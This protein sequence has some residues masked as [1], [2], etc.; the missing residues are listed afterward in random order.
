[1]KTD[2]PEV[3]WEGMD[4]TN[5]AQDGVM[6]VCECGNEPSGSINFGEFLDWIT[7]G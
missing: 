2:L 3:G 4:W 5:L 1:M 7:A 6:G